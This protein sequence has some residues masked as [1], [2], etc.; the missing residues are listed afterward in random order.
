MDGKNR[1][2]VFGCSMTRYMWPTWADILGMQYDLYENWATPGAGNLYISN[3]VCEANLRNKFTKDDT[4]IVLWSG[5]TR[6]DYHKENRWQPQ[7]PEYEF[8]NNDIHGYELI[9]YGYMHY[10]EKLLSIC[11][12]NYQMFSFG[13]LLDSVNPTDT[14]ILFSETLSNIKRVS[15]RC[16]N[17][18]VALEF[19]NVKSSFIE[20]L[21]ADTYEAHKGDEWPSFDDFM[22]G[23]LQLSEHVVQDINKCIS[24]ALKFAKLTGTT[25]HLTNDYH[26]TPRQHADMLITMFPTFK[27]TTDMNNFVSEWD[28]K[29]RANKFDVY[30]SYPPGKRC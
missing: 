24:S 3:S 13:S 23:Q 6:T 10:T 1:L 7:G 14:Q 2:F 29:V 28:R 9:N 25:I 4:V 5:I 12:V 30:K 19:K 16:Y 27:L 15:F 21:L 8:A 18:N 11:G 22:C 17:G 20:T 26:P